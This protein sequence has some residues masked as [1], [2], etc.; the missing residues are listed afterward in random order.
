MVGTLFKRNGP[1]HP[2][3]GQSGT[4]MRNYIFVVAEGTTDELIP[5]ICISH[6]F[7]NEAIVLDWS[8]S[9]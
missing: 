1:D 7:W 8:I 5:P 9:I 2:D 6:S 4:L 3:V